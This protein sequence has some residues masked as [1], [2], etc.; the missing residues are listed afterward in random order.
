MKPWV[1]EAVAGGLPERYRDL[2]PGDTPAGAAALAGK[3]GN[4]AVYIAGE[5]DKGVTRALA[6]YGTFY[7]HV[8]A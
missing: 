2:K 6:A 7:N 5:V 8:R 4:L 3:T 1:L